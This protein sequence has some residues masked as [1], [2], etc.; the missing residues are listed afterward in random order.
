[1]LKSEMEELLNRRE[2]QLNDMTKKC[3][4]LEADVKALLEDSKSLTH[5][6]K[7]QEQVIMLIDSLAAVLC[8]ESTNFQRQHYGLGAEHMTNPPEPPKDQMFDALQEIKTRLMNSGFNNIR[9][10]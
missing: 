1:M 2:L 3:R 10:L 5:H 9:L 4:G 8:P 7:T 6:Q